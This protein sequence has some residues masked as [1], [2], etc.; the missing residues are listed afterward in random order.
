MRERSKGGVRGWDEGSKGGQFQGRYRD[1][2]TGRYTVQTTTYNSARA[3]ETLV[4]QTKNSERINSIVY[5][6]AIMDWPVGAYG[7]DLVH[8]REPERCQVSI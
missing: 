2:D 1:E 3:I 5:V 8:N 7:M 4:L 6:M